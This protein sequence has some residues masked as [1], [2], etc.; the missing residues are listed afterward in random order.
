MPGFHIQT[1]DDQQ[2]NILKTTI[3]WLPKK[4]KTHNNLEKNKTQG[5]GKL[6]EDTCM[7]YLCEEATEKRYIYYLGNFLGNLDIN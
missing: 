2:S 3:I 6:R 4:K 7:M 5:E 1:S